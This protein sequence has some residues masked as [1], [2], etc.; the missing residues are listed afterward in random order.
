MSKTKKKK[1]TD[2]EEN[3]QEWKL[4]AM[5]SL[6]DSRDIDEE[7]SVIRETACIINQLEAIKQEENWEEINKIIDETIEQIKRVNIKI[8]TIRQE[9]RDFIKKLN[10]ENK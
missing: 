9:Y 6:V 4:E 3:K 8:A 5:Y 10:E 2:K 1:S 7:D